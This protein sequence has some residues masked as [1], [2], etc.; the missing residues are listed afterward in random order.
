M[1]KSWVPNFDQ[2]LLGAIVGIEIS[3]TEI[4]CKYKL[5]QNR[6]AED[7]QKVIEQLE[8][9]NSNVLADAMRG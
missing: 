7:Q 2:S 4:Q 8:N 3:I 1:E 5:S 6:S 9:R